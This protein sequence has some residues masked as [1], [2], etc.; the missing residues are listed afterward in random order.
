MQILNLLFVENRRIDCLCYLP[1]INVIEHAGC[2]NEERAYASSLNITVT[3][4]IQFQT[5]CLVKANLDR[6]KKKIL[7]S[8]YPVFTSQIFWRDK[9]LRVGHFS[10]FYSLK[11]NNILIHICLMQPGWSQDS[12]STESP[13]NKTCLSSIFH[14]PIFILSLRLLWIL[15]DRQS[16]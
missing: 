4:D 3:K 6:E 9:F 16:K 11:W 1:S 12:A 13:L 14:I 8:D 10:F 2:L 7:K 5:Q 15:P